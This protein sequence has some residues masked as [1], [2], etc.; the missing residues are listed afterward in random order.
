MSSCTCVSCRQY[1]HFFPIYFSTANFNMLL[2][3]L[4]SWQN[5]KVQ[6]EK[7]ANIDLLSMLDKPVQMVEILI[8]GLHCNALKG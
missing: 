7:F 2:V 4:F 3:V 5:I 1:K 6:K 8:E